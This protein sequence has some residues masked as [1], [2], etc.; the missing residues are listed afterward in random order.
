MDDIDTDMIFHNKYLAITEI[1]KM[2]VHTFETLEGYEDFAASA[3]PGDIVIAGGNFGCGSSR[4]AAV[5]CF[6]PLGVKLVITASTGAIYKRN[7]INSGFPFLEVSGLHEAGIEEG[8]EIE[9]D[10]E[11]GTITLPDGKVIESDPPTSVQL[12]ICKAGGLF[13]YTGEEE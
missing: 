7:I 12:D 6:I 13:A 4:Q 10:F 11:A 8:M 5:D 2:G 1:D 3:E 9:V